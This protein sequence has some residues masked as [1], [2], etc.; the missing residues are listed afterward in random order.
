MSVYHHDIH[1]RSAREV[2]LCVLAARVQRGQLLRHPSRVQDLLCE[3]INGKH[4]FKSIIFSIR[5]SQRVSTM[6]IPPRTFGHASKTSSGALNSC[7]GLLQ[8]SRLF[9]S[10]T[11][12]SYS[13]QTTSSFRAQRSSLLF[14]LLSSSTLHTPFLNIFSSNTKKLT[15]ESTWVYYL[16]SLLRST[17]SPLPSLYFYSS[18]LEA[19]NA[20]EIK[21]L[22]QS[23]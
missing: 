18:G 13:S 7:F 19:T 1:H 16:E 21:P 10:P 23:I 11:S 6:L 12:F 3:C 22:L 4:M 14:N 9:S 20:K 2:H 15:I 17:L 5:Y 8:P